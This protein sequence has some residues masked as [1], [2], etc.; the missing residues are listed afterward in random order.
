MRYAICDLQLNTPNTATVLTPP[1]AAAIAV[2]RIHGPGVA[3]FLSK[4]FSR[5]VAPLRCVHGELRDVGGAVIDDPVVVLSGDGAFADI[6]LHG[7][8]WVVASAVE[9]LRR[10]GFEIVDAEPGAP[11]P[12]EAVEGEAILDREMMSNLPLAKTEQGVRMLLAQPENWR[13]FI[14]SNP[15]VDA[16]QRILSDDC[17]TK[18]LHPPRVAIVG[19]PNVGK[20]TLANQLFA[21]QRCRQ[22]KYHGCRC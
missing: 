1:G 8:P 22:S 13:R 18:L 9:L 11:L 10:S 21:Q 15:S 4:H 5:R 20:S 19:A 3:E 16:V 6:N 7:G 14:P 12:L 17:L 2:I